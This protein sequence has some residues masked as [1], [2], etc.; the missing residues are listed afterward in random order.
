[1]IFVYRAACGGRD[2][3]QRA[4]RVRRAPAA[5]VVES[6]GMVGLVVGLAG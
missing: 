3:C 4:R 5:Y 2:L 1:M 6:K